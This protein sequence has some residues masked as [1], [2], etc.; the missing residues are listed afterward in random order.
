MVYGTIP[1]FGTR[2]NKWDLCDRKRPPGACV[3]VVFVNF[4]GTSRQPFLAKLAKL[5]K[6]VLICRWLPGIRGEATR[7]A[8]LSL[9][10]G[11]AS[12]FFSMPFRIESVPM[13]A[14]K[15]RTGQD[16]IAGDVLQGQAGSE[17]RKCVSLI[18]PV[19]NEEDAIDSFYEHIQTIL[20]RT[21]YE[22]EVLFVDDGSTDG[23]FACL[24]R[25][26][27]RDPRVRAVE[28]SRNYGKEHAL[29]AGLKLARGDAAIPMDV[30]LQD[31]PEVVHAFLAKW[32]EGC[33]T[34]IGVRRR[35]A[36]DSL[37]KRV[38]ASLFYR[39]YNLVCGKHLV[40]NAGDFRLLDRKCIT[41]LNALTERVRFTKG[42]Y[43]WIGFRQACVEYDRPPRVRGT[44]KWSGWKLWNLAL[45]GITS[46][47]SLPL[48]IWS[49]LGGC[50]ALLGFAYAL[51]LVLRTLVQGVDVPGYASL[52]VVTLCLGG[53]ILLSLGIIGEYLGRIFEEIKGRPLY[54]VR[55]RLGFEETDEAFEGGKTK[56]RENAA[57][58][59][60][61]CAADAGPEPQTGRDQPAGDR[62]FAERR[63]A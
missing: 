60:S 10:T 30:D 54:I 33:D 15:D 41:A 39:F 22:F 51:W 27:K 37:A 25:L 55:S 61:V 63:Q 31:P 44:S 36:T 21:D 45:D 47:S 50:L 48:R 46:F 40:S 49:Y 17:R 7:I 23:T 56:E 13:Q 29:A 32:E 43:A 16:R 34:V 8:L 20:T 35:R 53:L 57:A 6:I 14:D 4:S 59:A 58:P 12:T 2:V 38:S 24:E 3:R 18:V 26:H 19:Y 28:F 52:M 42:L 9:R 1:L 62:A 5:A 11:A